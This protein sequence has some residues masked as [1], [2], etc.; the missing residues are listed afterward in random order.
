[1]ENGCVSTV[2]ER[3]EVEK[4]TTRLK[5]A[6]IDWIAPEMVKHG[7]D[8]VVEWLTMICGLAWRQGE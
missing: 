3:V 1:M 4:A 8:A 6:S 2:I 7:G 5:A